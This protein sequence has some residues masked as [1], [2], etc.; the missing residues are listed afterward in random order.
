VH[1]YSVA[2]ALLGLVEAE[3]RRHAAA[4]VT[5][6]HVR[7]GALAGVEIALL[8]SAFEQ[9]RERTCCAAAKLDVEAVPVRWGCPR[10]ED[11]VALAP[12]ALRCARCGG[13]AELV[14][15]AELLLERV[16]LEVERV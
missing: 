1:E 2:S 5:R 7:V 16:E 10:C 4:Q 15:G 3:A 13:A 9:L 8:R 14:S 6:V 11:G 12:A